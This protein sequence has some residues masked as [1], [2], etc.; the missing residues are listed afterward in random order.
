MKII[1]NNVHNLLYGSVNEHLIFC[2]T[3][4]IVMTCTI[5][6][7]IYTKPKT[8][9]SLS[10]SPKAIKLMLQWLLNPLCFTCN[11]FIFAGSYNISPMG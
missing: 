5:I 3:F 11:A 10:H 2:S 6:L 7:K 8:Y 1:N 4:N 9:T